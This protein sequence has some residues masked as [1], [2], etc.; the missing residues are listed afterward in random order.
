M[1]EALATGEATMRAPSD[2]P[3]ESQNSFIHLVIRTVYFSFQKN[4]FL[5]NTILGKLFP[6][7]KRLKFLKIVL[8]QI[9]IQLFTYVESNNK[10]FIK[11]CLLR[12]VEV[13]IKLINLGYPT[14]IRNTI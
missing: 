3:L 7:F 5:E 8:M 11:S 6:Q 12:L 14:F 2:P 1:K 10:M 9:E 13:N 4:L